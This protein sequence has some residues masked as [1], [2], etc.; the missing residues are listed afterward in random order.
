MSGHAVMSCDSFGVA[1]EIIRTKPVKL[2]VID[3]DLP[4]SDP[5]F[6]SA[7]KKFSEVMFIAT[8]ASTDVNRAVSLMQRGASDY[9]VRPFKIGDIVGAVERGLAQQ[10]C[11]AEQFEIGSALSL[12]GLAGDLGDQVELGRT[13]E[14][15]ARTALEEVM[16]DAVS[17]VLSNPGGQGEVTHCGLGPALNQLH[18]VP[19]ARTRLAPMVLSGAAVFDYLRPSRE[20]ESIQSLVFIPL[21]AQKACMGWLMAAR[22]QGRPFSEGDRK[23]LTILA[24]RAGVAIHNAELFETLE[25]SFQQTIE[26]LIA[27][28]EEKDE[29]TAGHSERVADFARLI[30]ETLGLD[31]K[32]VELVHQGAR[33]HDIGKLAIRTEDLNKP[34]PLS[35]D[36][37]ERMKLHT[38]S[39]EELLK[40]IPFFQAIIPAVGGHH[41]RLDGSGYP[42]GL[43]GDEIPLLARIV[44][45]A[46]AYDAMTSD[47]AYRTA[48]PKEKAIAELRR[49]S[50][51]HY[52]ESCVEALA[53]NVLSHCI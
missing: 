33:L 4:D 29:Y 39:G 31:G 42:R 26:A 7:K 32:Q 12:Y 49:C 18:M 24:D 1:E 6:D 15:L 27:T 17:L 25:T 10:V 23:L 2:V 48:M 11:T 5:W 3:V 30:A 43:V 53:G 34:G 35:D 28:L 21:I 14:L 52:D 9:L 38:V 13:L 41:E 50:G 51:T 45:V 36:E 47:R 16:A 40:P 46:D 37:Y 44:A 8:T 22:T 19:S 20:T